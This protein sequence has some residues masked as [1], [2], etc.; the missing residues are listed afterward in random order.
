MIRMRRSLK[1]SEDGLLDSHGKSDGGTNDSSTSDSGINADSHSS[2]F[3]LLVSSLVSRLR[4]R[5]ASF[6]A[7]F[8]ASIGPCARPLVS[9]NVV[10]G[11][12]GLP[13]TC[14]AS[15]ALCQASKTLAAAK[16]GSRDRMTSCIMTC[17]FVVCAIVLTINVTETVS[18]RAEF[19]LHLQR[20]TPTVAVSQQRLR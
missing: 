11:T 2:H 5:C 3:Q 4:L 14:F 9:V 20:R 6:M 19:G 18:E 1:M 10:V 17:A 12:A 13:T 8:M 15:P 16:S 7:S